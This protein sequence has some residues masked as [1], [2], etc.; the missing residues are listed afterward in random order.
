MSVVLPCAFS[1]QMW[2]SWMLLHLGYFHPGRHVNSTVVK[3]ASSPHTGLIKVNRVAVEAQWAQYLVVTT[4]SAPSSTHGRVRMHGARG[5][6]M[7][8][9]GVATWVSGSRPCRIIYARAAGSSPKFG[10]CSVFAAGQAPISRSTGGHRIRPCC[11]LV[12]F[13]PTTCCTAC[14]VCVF[15]HSGASL[16]CAESS[17]ITPVGRPAAP[18]KSSSPNVVL[19]P[20]DSREYF[21]CSFI[22]AGPSLD[23]AASSSTAPL[24]LPTRSSVKA[25]WL[26]VLQPLCSS[27]ILDRGTVSWLASFSK[28]LSCRPVGRCSSPA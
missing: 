7:R 9:S 24:L 22:H 8:C 23:C 25:S 19:Y 5:L 10:L 27:C 28:P 1:H 2:R 17:S 12:V 15:I 3:N 26:S 16:D 13:H 18:S 11:I 21:V 14:C 6:P 4:L 20:I